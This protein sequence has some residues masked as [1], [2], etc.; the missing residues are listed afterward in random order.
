MQYKR[1][2][3]TDEDF[4]SAQN[5]LWMSYEMNGDYAMAYEI[6]IKQREKDEH[7]EDYKKAYAAAGWQGMIRKHFELHQVN[8]NDPETNFYSI[9]RQCAML[10]E[11]E[12]AFAYLNKAF[13]KGQYQMVFMYAEPRFDSLRD[14]PRFD[15]L[16]RRVGLN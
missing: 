13:E 4:V 6:F 5:Q 8:E 14:D 3:A 7:L 12:Q 9:A 1:V 10:G 2:L 16:V 15:E 11:K